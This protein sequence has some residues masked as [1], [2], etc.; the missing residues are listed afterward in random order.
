MKT[1][2]HVSKKL[3]RFTKNYMTPLDCQVSDFG[4]WNATVFYKNSKKSWLI[5]HA[6]TRYSLILPDVKAADIKT[7]NKTIYA[8]LFQQLNYDGIMFSEVD[9]RRVM[10]DVELNPTDGDRG[11]ISFM[12]QQLYALEWWLGQH[13]NLEDMPM[14]EYAHRLNTGP[15]KIG[16][17]SGMKNY[18]F[19]KELMETKLKIM[20][21]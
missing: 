12:N 16:G 5:S 14:H 7:I 15:T 21:N 9:L 13:D 19:P 6:E 17:G 10:G 3:E 8:N 2:I 20:G 18:F 11:T 4:K 1:K